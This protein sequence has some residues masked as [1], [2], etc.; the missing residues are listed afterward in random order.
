MQKTKDQKDRQTETE[1]EAKIEKGAETE[2]AKERGKEGGRQRQPVS[3]CCC[4]RPFPVAATNL[5]Q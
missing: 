1:T 4:L 5:K 2:T 3:L